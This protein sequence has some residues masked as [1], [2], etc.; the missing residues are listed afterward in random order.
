VLEQLRALDTCTVSNAIERFDVRLRNEGFTSISIRCFSPE[1]PPMVGYAVTGRI[2]TTTAP[3]GHRCY[4]QNMDFWEYIARMPAPR[5]IVIE[6]VDEKP[7]FAALFGEIHARIGLALGCVGYV[8]NGA[9]RDLPGI[10]QAGFHVYASGVSTSHAYAHVVDFGEQVSIG[11]LRVSPGDLLHGDAHGVVSVPHEIASRIPAHAAAL[12][13]KEK[14]LIDL[15]QSPGFSIEALR[16]QIQ[17]TK[18]VP[19]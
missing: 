3:A 4:H 8:T 13:A 6:D 9:L 10:R 19:K 17:R 1:L 14:E 12:L 15:C 11:G 18:H 7:A 5:I 2:R 16:H